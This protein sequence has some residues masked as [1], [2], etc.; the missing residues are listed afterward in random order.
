MIHG[1]SFKKTP[2]T[3]IN[4]SCGTCCFNVNLVLWIVCGL[5]RDW[6]SFS[7]SF[8]VFPHGYA[9]FMLYFCFRTWFFLRCCF[10]HAFIHPFCCVEMSKEKKV[11]IMIK[12]SLVII[13]KMSKKW[14]K[15]EPA[16]I[17]R[18]EKTR[19]ALNYHPIVIFSAHLNGKLN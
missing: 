10:G 12:T 18:S 8:S 14:A 16:N 3:N 19:N 6:T 11:Q 15:N 4:L 7:A 5:C 17:Y 1:P 13:W 9:V 2:R